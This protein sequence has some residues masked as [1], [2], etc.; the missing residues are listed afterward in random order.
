M[1]KGKWGQDLL[2]ENFKISLNLTTTNQ[3]APIRQFSKIL[4]LSISRMAAFY[5]LFEVKLRIRGKNR[6]RAYLIIFPSYNISLFLS[7]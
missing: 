3:I 5:R 1:I 6:S 7:V 2:K 4:N